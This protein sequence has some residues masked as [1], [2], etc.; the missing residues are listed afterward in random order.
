MLTGYLSRPSTYG[1]GCGHC[2][3]TKVEVDQELESGCCSNSTSTDHQVDN[4]WI[5]YT[6]TLRGTG[7][8]GDVRVC[9]HACIVFVCTLQVYV[10]IL[11]CLTVC[12]RVD[13]HVCVL[14]WMRVC[15]RARVRACVC[16]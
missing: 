2:L 15:V 13:L 10:C 16:V 1:F 11:V 6:Y 3:S 4:R 14:V 8:R 9:M 12:T 7:T 5:T